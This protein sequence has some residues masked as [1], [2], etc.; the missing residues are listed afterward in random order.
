MDVSCGQLTI[1]ERKR[2]ELAMVLALDPKLLLLDEVFA[3]L[4]NEE[5]EKL[6]KVIVGWA[7]RKAILIIEHRLDI[8]MGL[9]SR[10]IVMV[11]GAL[12]AD[13]TPAQVRANTLVQKAYLR[14]EQ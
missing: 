14:E 4:M 5:V 8:L 13:G 10:V 6:E 2:L 3:G 1:S 9:A 7:G 11:K 12:I